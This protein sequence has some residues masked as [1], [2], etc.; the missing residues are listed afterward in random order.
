MPSPRTSVSP[1]GRER[2]SA[3]TAERVSEKN[4]QESW[5][6]IVRPRQ[7]GVDALEGSWQGQNC[8]RGREHG[9][10][11]VEARTSRNGMYAL[12]TR[13]KGGHGPYGRY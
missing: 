2:K 5:W 11:G 1:W 12:D 10:N 6:S 3:R 7:S 8:T 4:K 9:V 13:L